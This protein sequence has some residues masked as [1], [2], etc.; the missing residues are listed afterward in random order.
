MGGGV[1]IAIIWAVIPPVSKLL[2][3]VYDCETFGAAD[4]MDA[5]SNVVEQAFLYSSMRIRCSDASDVSQEHEE[6]LT[7][8]GFFVAIWPVGMPLLLGGLLFAAEKRRSKPGFSVIV[9]S[10]AI[11][12]KE[13]EPVS[14]YWEVLEIWY[15]RQASNHG[16]SATL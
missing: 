16:F 2:F 10:T 6:L 8:S 3:S 7:L 12:S 1:C 14:F 11:I 15:R 13:Y 4:E 9:R 5:G